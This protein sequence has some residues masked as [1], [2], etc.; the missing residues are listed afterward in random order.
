[1]RSILS[2]Q[3]F[4]LIAFLGRGQ[5]LIMNEV[6][7]GVSGNMEYIEFVVV[8]SH[9]VYNC[10]LSI[11][12]TIDIRGWIFDDNSGY[13]GTGGVAAGAI[14]FS[15]DPLWSAVPLGTI[16]LVYNDVT[17]DP[18]IPNDDILLSDGNCRIVAPISDV[19]L[20]E[21][22]STTPGAVSCS[23]PATGWVPGGNW[24]RILMRN[25][26]DCIR[27]VN[28]SGC[29]VFSVCYGDVNLNTQI[30]FSAGAELPVDHRNTVYYFNDGDPTVQ[31]NWLI[32]CA[33]NET[34]LDANQCGTNLQTPGLPNNS[35][36]EQFVGR[37]NNYCNPIT[38]LILSVGTIS[39]QSCICNGSATITANG[40]NA[41]YSYQW[42]TENHSNL[43]QT[44]PTASN[45]CSGNYYCIVTS[46]SGCSDT[47]HVFVPSNCNA[48]GTFATA[49]MIEKCDT[50]QFYNT[51][52]GT[53]PD[54]INPLEINFQDYDFGAYFQNSNTLILKGG[55]VKTFKNPGS[56][57]CGA[58]L[59]YRIYNSST[60]T[61]IPPF[62]VLDLPFKEGCNLG[63]NNFPT[64]G[65][66]FFA[67]DQKW[68]KENYAI[69]LTDNMPGEYF[70]EVFYSAPGSYTSFA[71]CSDTLYVNNGGF[72]Y[73]AKFTIMPRPVISANGP[74]SFCEGNTVTLNSNYQV[75][76]EW[77]DGSSS[78]TLRVDSTGIY[79]LTVDLQN[80]CPVASDLQNITVYPLPEAS[81]SGGGTYCNPSPNFQ[82][83]IIGISNFGTPD[84]TLAYS[85]NGIAQ[86]LTLEN[87]QNIYIGAENGAN[88]YTLI[89]ISDQ[90][91]TQE[92]SE[93][94]SVEIIYN[95]TFPVIL[96]GDSTY[97]L[98]DKLKNLLV[99]TNGTTNWYSDPAL[100]SLIG[101][102]DS[103][104][105]TM[106]Y[107]ST[108]YYVQQSINDCPGV[109]GSIT[110]VI[111]NCDLVIPSA[112]T[113][114]GDNINDFWE[115][116]NL[117]ALYPNNVVTIFDRWG[118]EIFNSDPGNYEQGPWD[119]T[120]R[121]I[122]LPVASYYYVIDTKSPGKDLYRGSVTIVRD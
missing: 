46:W 33:D 81:I 78:D 42:F 50:N 26:G 38:P 51:T 22:N 65:P 102:G 83:V 117:D 85:V 17:P 120:Y 31:S 58:K 5:T 28:L 54:Q 76:N 111:E 87:P 114:D 10:G 20:F 18:S 53:P 3:F 91:C 41:P 113:P 73:K 109:P 7:Q 60:L 55:E 92:L 8:D 2:L 29:E 43:G 48:Y 62:T 108:V 80:G 21:S 97:C 79:L 19:T 49:T 98:G 106:V 27:L 64:G 6:S 101:T 11:P 15:N 116:S 71:D 68:A 24:S 95:Q 72:N 39:G 66:C 23:Y 69:D 47:I 57:V 100:T 82:P 93:S 103:L 34:I 52:W 70:V 89:S 99:Q 104:T 122:D 59:H 115:L 107:D 32:G 94:V 35:A 12:P 105:P 25:A 56:N 36:N 4:I 74:I 112:I 75:G 110:I 121:G 67:G 37:F 44:T 88:T 14:R 63:G 84:Y 13:H 40:S 86:Q 16:I 30:Y 1:M 119:G 118:S 61:S 90:F 77:S 45:L 96:S 9:A